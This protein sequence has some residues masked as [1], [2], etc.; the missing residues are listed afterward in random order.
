LDVE[1]PLLRPIPATVARP[2]PA[3][4][5]PFRQQRGRRGGVAPLGKKA[6]EGVDMMAEVAHGSGGADAGPAEDRRP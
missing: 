6:T 1:L 2:R 3:D 4:P 5:I